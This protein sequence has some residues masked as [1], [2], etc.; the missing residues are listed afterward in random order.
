V[1]TEIARFRVRVSDNQGKH[2]AWSNEYLAR[3]S[4]STDIKRDEPVDLP[5][6]E[7]LA[8]NFPNPFNPHTTIRFRLHSGGW[9]AVDVY[10]VLGRLTRTLVRRYLSAGTHE[11][12]WDGRDE[13]RLEVAGGVYVYRIAGAEYTASRTMLLLR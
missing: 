10:D 9:T 6:S 8:S 11:V 4:A 12:T 1:G 3:F 7:V 5:H 2:S 13:N